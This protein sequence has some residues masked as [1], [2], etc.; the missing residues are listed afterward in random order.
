MALE[1]VLFQRFG[2]WVNM[3]RFCDHFLPRQ[4]QAKYFLNG[5]L[6]G[7]ASPSDLEAYAWRPTI[8]IF[9]FEWAIWHVLLRHTWQR[10]QRYWQLESM[11]RWLLL[12]GVAIWVGLTI[13]STVSSEEHYGY[14]PRGLGS[15]Y[16]S[17][18]IAVSVILWAWTCRLIL[19]FQLRKF[20][21]QSNENICFAC[22]YDLRASPGACPECG[23]ARRSESKG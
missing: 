3:V 20:E 18:A 11:T 4:Q 13:L 17:K 14:E 6:A 10:G 12:A 1:A 5:F 8:P 9:L 16:A 22:G 21:R 7:R 2:W 23:T 15:L 19:L